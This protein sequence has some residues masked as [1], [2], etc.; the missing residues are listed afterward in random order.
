MRESSSATMET[1]EC[2]EDDDEDPACANYFSQINVEKGSDNLKIVQIDRSNE[3]TYPDALVVL[4][5]NPANNEYSVYRYRNDVDDDTLAVDLVF[6]SAVYSSIE[7]LFLVDDEYALAVVEGSM[8]KVI[9]YYDFA[10][11]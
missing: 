1:M 2:E 5:L 3:A 6:K 8:V 9:Y 7:A 10:G 4:E 11:N